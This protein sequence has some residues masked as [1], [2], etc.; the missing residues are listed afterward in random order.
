MPREGDKADRQSGIG[1][2]AYRIKSFSPGVRIDLERFA[3]HW[4]SGRESKPA[5]RLKGPRAL[6]FRRVEALH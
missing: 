6:I 2:G 4:D 3:D 1:A 5:R